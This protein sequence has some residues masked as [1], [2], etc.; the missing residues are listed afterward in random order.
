MNLGRIEPD[1]WEHV[2]K[3]TL[4]AATMPDAPVPVTAGVNWYSSF[5]IPVKDK[6][7]KWWVGRNSLGRIRG[8]HAICLPHKNAD[9]Y[10]WYT[11]YNQGQEGAC[12]GF[13]ASRMMSLLN[14]ERYDARWLYK[15]AQKVDEWEGENYEGTSVR[16]A[17]DILRNQ[18]HCKVSAGAVVDAG[19]SVNRWAESIDQVLDV[20]GNDQYKKL[21]AI[22]F[23]NS[24]G[25]GYP[26]RVWMPCEVWDRLLSEWGEFTIIV[27]K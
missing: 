27:D 20:L 6:D 7:G 3:Y 22:P 12:V 1:T 15:E 14:R 19:I 23:H 11:Y 25:K 4:R 17:M 5:D 2:E 21:G 26:Q 8:G 16:A 9:T 24:W 18:G 10:G 13:A